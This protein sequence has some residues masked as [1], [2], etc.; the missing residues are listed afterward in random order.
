M[1]ARARLTRLAAVLAALGFLLVALELGARWIAGPVRYHDGESLSYD[2]DLGFRETPGLVIESGDERGLFTLRFNREGFRGR[3]LPEPGASTPQGVLRVAFL[4]DSFL[5]ARAVRDE[6][7]MTT[8]T[9]HE[10]VA[11]GVPTEVY[12]LSATDY[13]T[14]QQLLLL[15]EVGADLR[16]DVVILALY[17]HNDLANNHL[18][19]AGR[20]AVSPGDYLRPYLVP[21]AEGRLR[22]RHAY[23][24][25]A[26]LRSHLHSFAVFERALLGFGAARE[27]AWL[28]PWPPPTPTAQRLDSG[29][30]PRED[31]EIFRRHSADP[32]WEDA[33]A[34]T[35]ALLRA[36]RAETRASNARL[37]VLVIPYVFQVQRDATSV[38]MELEVQRH[39]IG[40]LDALLD[41]NRPEQRLAR[42]FADEGIE[43]RLLLDPLR[44]A[45]RDDARVYAQDTHL[46]GRGHAIAA[47]EVLAWLRGTAP[48]S[49]PLSTTAPT[50]LLPPA[51]QALA[52]LDFR[53]E[54]HEAY[55]VWGGWIAWRAA[56]EGRGRGWVTSVA[57]KLL[58]PA[59]R[60]DLIV[61]GALPRQAP[62]PAKV[63][64][65]LSDGRRKIF[66]LTRHGSFTLRLP[67]APGDRD[68]NGFVSVEIRT[69]AIF[70]ASG[71]RYGL[72]LEEIG[73]AA[74]A[75]AR[76]ET[77]SRSR[78]RGGRG[79]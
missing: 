60:G 29:R 38:A 46:N 28:A 15:R 64:L 30:A 69:D 72:F 31:L 43:A 39:G 20:T 41:W 40:S 78:P 55:L 54:A 42:F 56:L 58:L 24:L 25:R 23:P 37:L 9:Q 12:N 1:P 7:L 2:P 18:G 27:I 6:Q 36:V 44:R 71:R 3:P 10:L 79:R 74:H 53:R 73:F 34:T 51:S 19:L 8:L 77:I 76:D 63:Q 17:P 33:W 35:F 47:Q 75:P 13:G 52:W 11:D 22:V 14:V 21:T 59:R 65:D 5:V 67:A 26:W 32:L 68:P 61:R 66:T 62:L 50:P 4:G 16:P 49:I 45:V 48:P 70:R 57:P